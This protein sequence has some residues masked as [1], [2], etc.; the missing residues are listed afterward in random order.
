MTDARANGFDALRLIAAAMVI[1]GHAYPLTGNS[2]IGFLAN[3]VQTI[4]VKT[5]FVISGFLIARSWLSDPDL[6]R[7]WSK[8]ALRIMPGLIL[9][10][11]I[12]VF[13]W[14]PAVSSLD[15]AEYFGSQWTWSYFW[16]VLLYPIYNLPGVFT[17]NIY[18]SAVNGSL[19]SL[20]V[21]VAMY[22]GIPLFLGPSRAVGRIIVPAMAC[23]LLI[24]SVVT[25]RLSPPSHQ[26]VF[27]GSS[28]VSTLDAAFYFYAGAT[29]AVH[30][31]DRFG[32]VALSAILFLTAALAVHS[33]V[34][35]EVALGAVLPFFVI[36]LGR[37]SIASLRFL[38]G[39]DY[40]YGLYLYGFIVQQTLVHF[41]GVHSPIL[42]GLMALPITLVFAVVSWHFVERRALS[43]KP[44][45]V[46]DVA[47]PLDAASAISARIPA[48]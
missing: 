23:S 37:T 19:W 1:F 40:S 38:R 46:T 41:L 34:W 8:R 32:N 20:P 17:S 7:F 35:G 42:D 27:W 5:F 48:A 11:L 2:S 43:M 15:L 26:I 45:R 28:L 22:V 47:N 33:Y 14:G 12:T 6:L 13:V 16:N 39:H 31:L 4:G 9:I 18:P 29:I 30:R 36:S 44:R 24:A 25:V 3:T 10:C 21:E